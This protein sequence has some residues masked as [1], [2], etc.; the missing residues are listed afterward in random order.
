MSVAIGSFLLTCLD[1]LAELRDNLTQQ[2][3]YL[4]LQPPEQIS[5]QVQWKCK[6]DSKRQLQSPPL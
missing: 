3:L 2:G 5:E 4:S 1:G 6:Q